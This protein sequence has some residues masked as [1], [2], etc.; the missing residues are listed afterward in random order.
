EDGIRDK[1]VTGVQT[2]ALPICKIWNSASGPSCTNSRQAP[3]AFRFPSPSRPTA[4]IWSISAFAFE[5][6]SAW[7]GRAVPKT[8]TET[9]KAGRSEERR[10]GKEGRSRWEQEEQ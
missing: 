6:P 1:L 7:P 9:I 10:V 4:R 5:S 3:L 2:C 8:K